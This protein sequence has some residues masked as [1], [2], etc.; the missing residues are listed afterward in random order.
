MTP[1]HKHTPQRTCVVCRQ[2]FDKRQLM[3]LVKTPEGVFFDPSGKRDG[4]GAYL[5][6]NTDC[7]HRVLSTDI[8]NRALRVAL[9]D[10]DRQRIRDAAS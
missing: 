10:E 7:H 3:R 4:R 9:T 6:S 5:C 1:Q 2:K 8:L